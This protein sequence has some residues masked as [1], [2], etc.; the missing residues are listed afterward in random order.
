[1]STVYQTVV[2]AL[3][4]IAILDPTETPAAQQMDDAIGQLNRMCTRWE[5][6]GI[7]IGWVNVVNP[8]DTLPCPFENE[9]AVIYNLATHLA[10][11]YGVVPPPDVV[12]YAVGAMDALGRDRATEMPLRLATRIPYGSGLSR[13]SVY[14]TYSGNLP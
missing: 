14:D 2:S 11:D 4:K 9:D 3:R 7:A 10:S 1:M 12:A 8:S 13:S 5:A 6:D